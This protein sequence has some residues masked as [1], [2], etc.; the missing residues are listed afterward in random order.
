MRL[1]AARPPTLAACV[2]AQANKVL[3]PGAAEAGSPQSFSSSGDAESFAAMLSSSLLFA[4]ST[5]VV[6]QLNYTMA[7]PR[8]FPSLECGCKHGGSVRAQPF[9]AAMASFTPQPA[10]EE[11][12]NPDNFR[13]CLFLSVAVCK[14]TYCA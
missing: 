3:Q 7:C 2:A 1:E 5:H 11:A 9:Q 8:A 14:W 12:E 10:A 6:S 13:F 4:I